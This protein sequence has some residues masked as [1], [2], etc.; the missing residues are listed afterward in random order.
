M[1]LIFTKNQDNE[2]DVQLTRGTI[3]ES[4]SYT[5]MIKQLLAQNSFEDTEFKDISQEE[6]TRIETMLQNINN[7]IIALN[8]D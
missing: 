5:E 7:S 2:I 4:F 3:V 8:K 6:K 1:K